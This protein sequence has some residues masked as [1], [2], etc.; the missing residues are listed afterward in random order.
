L[1]CVR[2]DG[3]RKILVF[4]GPLIASHGNADF[5]PQALTGGPKQKTRRIVADAGGLLPTTETR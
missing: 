4:G 3:L 1:R 2:R 5:S